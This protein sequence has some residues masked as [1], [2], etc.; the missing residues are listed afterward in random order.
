[1]KKFNVIDKI[2]INK[3]CQENNLT[4]LGLFGSYARGQQQPNSDIDLL[5]E[6]DKGAG[7]TLF[8]VGK[9][10][11]TLE[12]KL[13]VDVD[14]IDKNNIKSEFKPNIM[15]DLITLYEKR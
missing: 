7:I 6:L 4:Y 9:I 11:Y 14:F 1:M 5:F 2:N 8:G 10:V 13:G 15:D 12:K 3:F